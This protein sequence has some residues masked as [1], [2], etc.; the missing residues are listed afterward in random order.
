MTDYESRLEERRQ[1][2]KPGNTIIRDTNTREKVIDYTENPNDPNDWSVT[3]QTLDKDGKPVGEPRTHKTPPTKKEVQRSGFKTAEEIKTGVQEDIEADVDTDVKAGAF[4]FFPSGVLNNPTFKFDP[5]LPKKVIAWM[6]DRLKPGG[7]LMPKSIFGLKRA[8][9]GFEEKQIQ[10]AK[11]NLREVRSAVKDSYPNGRPSKADVRKINQYLTGDVGIELPPA[12]YEVLDRMRD[13]VDMLSRQMIDENVID[14]KLSVVFDNNMG[15]YFTRNYKIYQDSEKWIRHIETTPEGQAIRNRA[16]IWL[17]GEIN[18]QTEKLEKKQK[19]KI[20]QAQRFRDKAR[21]LPDGPL[22]EAMMY[23]AFEAERIAENYDNKI[24]EQ[25]NRDA[26]AEIQAI[27]DSKDGPLAY[28]REGKLGQKDLGIVSK[29]KDISPEIRALLGEIT[30]P[31]SKYVDSVIKM[32]ALLA[33]HKFLTAARKD[34]LA[35]GIFVEG[36][37]QGDK[38]VLIAP[39]DSKTMAPL[40]GIYTTIEIA[41]SFQDADKALNNPTWVN[42]LVRLNAIAKI[43]K[44]VLSPDSHVRNFYANP[45]IEVANGGLSFKGLKK[46]VETN[47]SI[48]DMESITSLLG[49]KNLTPKQRIES[50]RLYVQEM[51][52]LG[53]INEGSDYREIADFFDNLSGND[54]EYRDF[55]NPTIK[56]T[57]KKSL[58]KA[59]DFYKAGDDFWKIH[60]FETELARLKDAYGDTKTTQELKKEA[61]EIVLNTR[62]NYSMAPKIVK[63]FARN[64]FLAP[65]VTFAS[66]SIRI[67]YGIPNQAIKEMKSGNAKIKKVG[68]QRMAGFITA[69]GVTGVVDMVSRALV[70]MDDEEE[71]A[72]RMFLA[73]WSQNSN[74]IWLSKD[75]YV[76]VGYTDSFGYVKKPVTAFMRAS[77]SI[78]G[79]IDASL[80]LFSPFTNPEIG[81]QMAMELRENQDRNGNKIYDKSLPVKENASLITGYIAKALE[82]GFVTKGKRIYKG[83]SG[84]Y[85]QA[86]KKY[87]R[88]D[89][90]AL[91]L[92]GFKKETIDWDK[93]IQFKMRSAGDDIRDLNGIYKKQEKTY[94]DNDEKSRIATAEGVNEGVRANIQELRDYYRSAIKIGVSPGKAIRIMKDAGLSN[95]TIE[96]S[97]SNKPLDKYQY[98]IIAPVGGKDVV[99]DREKQ[100]DL[101]LNR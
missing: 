28:I 32:S 58:Q 84:E 19:N 63:D 59:K 66:E 55:L 7:G 10:K 65:F 90:A 49:D 64:V 38:T 30:D 5:R 23:K 82:P 94:A 87:S 74:L 4:F 98:L 24:L 16:V 20:R 33:N 9:E 81:T 27:L 76:D 2:Y 97:I 56:S 50:V 52:E 22:K 92:T 39:K 77:N 79:V 25:S 51:I 46:A 45:I 68:I 86:G 40:D 93:A 17:Q 75:S 96:M 99:I 88:L 91:T 41:Q 61:A 11:Y 47:A 60:A 43:G 31:V 18:N 62:I 29:R 67:T 57:G 6:K 101:G 71:E 14:D 89:E 53:V 83:E 3:T 85:S 73:P 37:P 36:R 21:E 100:R 78:K 15:V 72:R 54:Y 26:Q 12:M 48:L 69:M 80:E 44:T 34:G 95:E 1:A 42:Y 13:H 35:S 70:Q 8:K